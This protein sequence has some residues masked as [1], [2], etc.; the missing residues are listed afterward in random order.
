MTTTKKRPSPTDASELRDQEPA[1]NKTLW[2]RMMEVGTSKD[3]NLNDA[4]TTVT[5]KKSTQVPTIS[6]VLADSQ[7]AQQA[8]QRLRDLHKS[9]RAVWAG[10]LLFLLC[11]CAVAAVLAS[12]SFFF[13]T[14]S[15]QTLAESQFEAITGRALTQAVEIAERNKWAMSTMAEVVGQSQP[16]PGA[17]PFV[18]VPGFERIGLKLH[19][20]AGTSE[21]LSLAPLVTP[22]QLPEWETFAYDYLVQVKGYPI[23]TTGAFSFTGEPGVWTTAENGTIVRDTTGIQPGISNHHVL[24][25]TLQMQLEANIA[26]MYNLRT[27]P[28]RTPAIDTILEAKCDDYQNNTDNDNSS[29]YYPTHRCGAISDMLQIRNRETRG[30]AAILYQGI[31]PPGDDASTHM[32]GDNNVT[33]SVPDTTYYS[34]TGGG[35]RVRALASR[36]PVALDRNVCLLSLTHPFSCLRYL[37]SAHR[38]ASHHSSFG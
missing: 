37:S 10:R 23:N 26:L 21:L 36:L 6:S 16:N 20:S 13:L 15:E 33:N 5:Q 11:L 12:C 3:R 17:W 27:G 30:P 25:P 8:A 28:I 32:D 7:E 35:Q 24:F 34:A 22:Q 14:R 18:I 9:P 31:Y 19:A 4:A 38:P 2:T 1:R 29:S